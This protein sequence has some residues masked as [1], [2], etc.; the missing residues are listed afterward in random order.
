MKSNH[1]AIDPGVK[2]IRFLDFFWAALKFLIFKV[3]KLILVAPVA[4]GAHKPGRSNIGR[5]LEKNAVKFSKRPALYFEDQKWTWQEFNATVNRYANYF[6]SQGLEKGDV[7]VVLMDN[8]PQMLFAVAAAAKIGAVASLVNTGLRKESLVHCMTVAPAKFYLIQKELVPFFEEVRKDLPRGGNETVYAVSDKGAVPEGYLDLESFVHRAASHNP[9]TVAKVLINITPED[10]LYNPLSLFHTNPMKMAWPTAHVNG[11]ALVLTRKFSTSGFWDV[12]RKY[13]VTAFNYV[14]ELCTYLYNAPQK[15]D[16][17]DNPVRVVVGNGMR[18]NIFTGFKKRFNINQ[19]MELYGA[20][21]FDMSL[22]NILNQEETI[23]MMMTKGAVVKY[24][25]STQTF[26]RDE[27]GRMKKIGTGQAG[28]IL[29]GADPDLLKS[30]STCQ[31]SAY[32][33]LAMV[34]RPGVGSHS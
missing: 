29:A 4:F 28:L 10:V 6:I 24:D 11:A 9:A 13:N 22:M 33:R 21:E 27:N 14:G 23:G 26:D 15:T 34:W 8:C 3:P 7:F 5:T 1:K 30:F 31:R 20:S 16:D 25:L 12:V 19:V 32:P 2:R 18:T 17:G